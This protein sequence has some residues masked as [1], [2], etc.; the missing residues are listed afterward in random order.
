MVSR[1]DLP[2][3]ENGLIWTHFITVRDVARSRKFYANILGGEVVLTETPGIVRVAN[4]WITMNPGGE[5]TPDKP[6]VTL[7]ARMPMVR[8]RASSMYGQSISQNSMRRS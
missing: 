3:P 4:S 6:D 2:A 1:E 5:P 7:T 8:Y